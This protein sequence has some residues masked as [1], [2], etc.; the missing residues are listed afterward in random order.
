MSEYEDFLKLLSSQTQQAYSLLQRLD[1]ELSMPNIPMPIMGSEIFWDNIAEYN[2]WRLQQNMI[3]QHARILDNNN[4][5]VAWGSLKA[6]Q[7]AMGKMI[8]E[9]RKRDVNYQTES[10]NRLSAMDELKKLKE[11]YDIGALTQNEFEEKK[12]VLMNRI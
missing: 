4:V 8:L 6:M 12:A 2:G 11:L 10:Q 3:T 9:S 1:E 5:R 7:K